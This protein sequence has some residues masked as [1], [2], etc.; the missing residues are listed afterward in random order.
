MNIKVTVKPGYYIVTTA[1]R[2]GIHTQAVT[3]EKRC[4]CGRKACPHI[5]AVAEYLRNG[6]S[7]APVKR[8]VALQLRED[9]TPPSSAPLTCPICGTVVE[10]GAHS[11]WRCPQD[12]SHYW[13]W[14]G[15]AG[16]VKAFLT[17][18]HHAKSGAFYQQTVEERDVFLEQAAQRMHQGGYTPHS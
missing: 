13:Q 8:E 5:K 6:G 7:R 3:K 17:Q 1:A 16:G 4:T 12:R 10:R 11:V 18:P 14:R 2:W 9:S 15:E